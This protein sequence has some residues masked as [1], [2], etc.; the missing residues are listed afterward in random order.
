MVGAPGIE[1]ESHA[2]NPAPFFFGT[3]RIK[4]GSHA[5]PALLASGHPELNWGLTHPK[6][7]YYHCTMPRNSAG[8]ACILT[9]YKY[10]T[11]GAGRGVYTTTVLCPVTVL[12]Q[13]AKILFSIQH[14]L[15]F[16]VFRVGAPR[17]ELGSYPPHGHILPLY[18]APINTFAGLRLSTPRVPSKT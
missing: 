15:F 5:H 13:K 1:P 14:S 4:L 18:Y 16:G 7:V 9:L 6:R 2:P 17:I 3:P 11:Q 8:L 12:G 10:P